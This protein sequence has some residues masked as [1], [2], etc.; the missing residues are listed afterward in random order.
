MDGS[1]VPDYDVIG[2]I[3][4]GGFG[5]VF[6]GRSR[7]DGTVVAIK[8]VPGD[9]DDLPEFAQRE[10]TVLDRV[11]VRPNSSLCSL[12]CAPVRSERDKCLYLVFKYF[13]CDLRVILANGPISIAHARLCVYGVLRGLAA[14]HRAGI[15]HRDLKP[16]NIFLDVTNEAALGDFGLSRVPGEALTDRVGT[17]YYWAPEQLLGDQEYGPAIDIWA[18]ACLMFEMVVGEPLFRG[19]SDSEQFMKMCRMIG[20][21]TVKDWPRMLGLPNSALFLQV[22]GIEGDLRKV[23]KERICDEDY[24]ELMWKMLRWDPEQRITAENALEE[25]VFREVEKLV[26]RLPILTPKEVVPVEK[27]KRTLSGFWLDGVD[28]DLEVDECVPVKYVE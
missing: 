22:K 27:E 10:V 26:R 23:M 7:N 14:I 8:S 12:L 18:L 9:I 15:I 5:S 13:P 11:G 19:A 3:A 20:A 28:I 21:P 17:Q 2:T 25:P 24:V 16:E 6:K 1:I 4:C